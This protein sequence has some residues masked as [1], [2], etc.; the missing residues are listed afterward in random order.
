MN[1]YRVSLWGD[2]TV[3]ELDGGD[4]GATCEY[5]ENHRIVDFERVN[6]CYVNYI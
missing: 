2:E 3:V 6:L 4:G 1:E 5:T